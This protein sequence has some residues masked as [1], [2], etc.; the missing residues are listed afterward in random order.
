MVSQQS[1]SNRICY[2][3]YEK[4]DDKKYEADEI[5]LRG[6]LE[7]RPS[8]LTKLSEAIQAANRRTLGGLDAAQLRLYQP[9]AMNDDGTLNPRRM[10]FDFS[11]INETSYNIFHEDENKRPLI[12]IAPALAQHEKQLL[13]REGEL[14]EARQ[15]DEK[16]IKFFSQEVSQLQ[17]D[18]TDHVN[19]ERMEWFDVEVSRI[20]WRPCYSYILCSTIAFFETIY[21]NYQTAGPHDVRQKNSMVLTGVQ[22]T[23]KSI[24][25]AII[26]LIMGK[27]FGWKVHYQWGDD[28]DFV[29]G[30]STNPA[31]KVIHVVDL[32]KAPQPK[33]PSGFLLIISSANQVRWH[34]LKQQQ[35]W[36]ERAG[37]YCFI[38]PASER[39][40]EAMVVK[41]RRIP[42]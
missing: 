35:T 5:F 4:R 28:E 36:S 8:T 17:L 27:I 39:E 11:S 21:R 14:L 23:G 13:V 22:G 6:E 29:F 30:K 34:D 10:L 15:D 20:Y 2:V 33:Y 24:L 40:I 37:N 12:V 38:D 32:S 7:Q 42:A 26:A 9:G 18:K 41:P 1:R 19:V 25:G 3:V 31:A 16:K